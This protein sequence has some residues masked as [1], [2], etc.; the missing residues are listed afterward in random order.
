MMSKV[1]YFTKTFIIALVVLITFSACGKKGSPT[2]P[3][4][5]EITYPKNY[6]AR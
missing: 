3:L 2:P 1:N 5:K 4:G 6:P